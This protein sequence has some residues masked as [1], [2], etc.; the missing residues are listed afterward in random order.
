LFNLDSLRD[1]FLGVMVPTRLQLVITAVVA[2]LINVLANGETVLERFGVSVN[3]LTAGQQAVFS[4]YDHLLRSQV[5][6]QIA[7]VTFWATVGLVAYLICWGCYNL[8]IE[9]R[10]E[11]TLNTAYTNRG[12]HRE[13]IDALVIK[14]AAAAC[15]VAWLAMSKTVVTMWLGVFGSGVPDPSLLGFIAMLGAVGGIALHLYL[16]YVLVELTFRPWYREETF[17]EA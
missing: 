13:A 10:N 16:L 1:H 11:V 14:V 12:D 2:F 7:L 4:G 5:A 6:S 3:D 9:A 15:L 8:L 17:T